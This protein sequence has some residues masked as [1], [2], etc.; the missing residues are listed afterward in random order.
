MQTAEGFKAIETIKVGELVAARDELAGATHWQRVERV[1]V[2]HDREVID[3]IF[4]NADGAIELITVTPGH[5][6]ATASNGWVEAGALEQGAQIQTLDERLVRLLSKSANTIS[7]TTYNLTVANDHS[8]FVGASGI[9]VH[10]VCCGGARPSNGISSSSLEYD[11]LKKQL[12]LQELLQPVDPMRGPVLVQDPVAGI[13][14]AQ[15]AQI[16]RYVQISNLALEE[17]YLSPTGRVSTSG[18][19]RSQ[20]SAA[21]AAERA[22][23]VKKGTPYLG[24]VGHG[25][26]TTWTGM[27]NPPF[28]MDLE[29]GINSSLGRQSLNYPVG[30][31]P[32]GFIYEGDIE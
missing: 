13:T 25:P 6:F 23:A 32:T 19:M 1:V 7:T 20:A 4:V 18:T 2:N 16:R 21:A 26:D 9:W 10:N 17:G 15:K 8:Y 14:A 29:F 24:V 22:K 12:R 28:W 31:K 5:W 3:L 30:H 27:A 11:E